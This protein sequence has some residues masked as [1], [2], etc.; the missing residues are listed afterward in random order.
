MSN[1]LPSEALRTQA[2]AAMQEA[3]KLSTDLTPRLPSCT[4]SSPGSTALSLD[5]DARGVLSTHAARL[6][7]G[8][9]RPQ[10]A[11]PAAT[12]RAGRARDRRRPGVRQEHPRRRPHA[13]T[14]D[15]EQLDGL[16]E[17][18]IAAHPVGE[19]GLVEITTDYPDVYPFLTFATRPRAPATR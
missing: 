17:D 18:Y 9:R 13:S 12:A 8:G 11:G 2:E 16:P 3:Q 1:V 14:L 6:P 5:D 19:D 4:R 10:R 15:P 7:A